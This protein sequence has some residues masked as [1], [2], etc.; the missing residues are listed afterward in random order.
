MFCNELRIITARIS[1]YGD[2][3]QFSYINIPISK[4]TPDGETD[5]II[6][7]H[8]RYPRG[9]SM[10]TWSILSSPVELGDVTF[11]VVNVR[12]RDVSQPNR[13]Y[14][15]DPFLLKLS[16]LIGGRTFATSDSGVY[17]GTPGWEI[18]KDVTFPVVNVRR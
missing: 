12:K 14:R 8:G 16:H 2:L 3:V 11:L 15:I 1:S 13:G 18:W 17:S 4:A 6:L 9:H 10:A 7:N 5:L